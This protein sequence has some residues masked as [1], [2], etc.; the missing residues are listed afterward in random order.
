MSLLQGIGI[1]LIFFDWSIDY[2]EAR[3]YLEV[4]QGQVV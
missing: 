1:S 4:N 3:D 2:S